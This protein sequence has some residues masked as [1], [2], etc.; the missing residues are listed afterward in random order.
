[1]PRAPP[2]ASVA[3]TARLPLDGHGTLVV[4][5]ESKEPW[6]RVIQT[7]CLGSFSLA[8]LF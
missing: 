2:A 4:P 6:Y 7:R 1:M 3:A 8:D 5:I